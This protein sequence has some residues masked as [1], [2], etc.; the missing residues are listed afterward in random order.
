MPL[1]YL[2]WGYINKKT[3]KDKIPDHKIESRYKE[4]LKL[5]F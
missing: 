5:I 3:I 2:L 4:K 1:T